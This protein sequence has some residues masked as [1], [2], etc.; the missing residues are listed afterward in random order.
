MLM[1]RLI[2]LT[3]I[4][5]IEILG[6]QEKSLLKETIPD[7][8]QNK[9]YKELDLECFQADSFHV[10]TVRKKLFIHHGGD[11]LVFYS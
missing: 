4:E 11:D 10:P 6:I 9:F 7:K 1:E 5:I 2:N 8:D 3:N